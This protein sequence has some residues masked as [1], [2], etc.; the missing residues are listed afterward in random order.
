MTLYK[1]NKRIIVLLVLICLAATTLLVYYQHK[2]K[3][4]FEYEGWISCMPVLSEKQSELCRQ[5]EEADY[6]YI[7]Y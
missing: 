1:N 7:A 2:P 3:Q 6:P 4:K 5:A